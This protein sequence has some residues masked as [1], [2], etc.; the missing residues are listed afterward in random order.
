MGECGKTLIMDYTK[1]IEKSHEQVQL[2]S[3]NRNTEKGSFTKQKLSFAD[4]R[5]SAITQRR[6]QKVLN[7]SFQKGQ[8]LPIQRE[9]AGSLKTINDVYLN[10]FIG[11][12][13]Q[14][15][16]YKT[17]QNV[18][19]KLQD[20]EEIID[21]DDTL[22]D[23]LKKLLIE[24]DLKT[25]ALASAKLES[26]PVKRAP[27]VARSEPE[28]TRGEPKVARK[29]PISVKSEQERIRE[30]RGAAEHVPGAHKL[31]PEPAKRAPEVARSEPEPTAVRDEP[32]AAR[33]EPV[34]VKS[35]QEVVREE[36]GAA[37]HVPGPHNI[38]SLDPGVHRL[39]PQTLYI[40]NLF[41]G[42]NRSRDKLV[43]GFKPGKHA[44][45]YLD[46]LKDYLKTRTPIEA[47]TDARVMISHRPGQTINPTDKIPID[48]VMSLE[49]IKTDSSKPLILLNYV[50]TGPDTGAGSTTY[51][52][53]VEEI[54]T[55]TSASPTIGFYESPSGVKI[56]AVTQS[57]A[58]NTD[59]IKFTEYDFLTPIPADKIY[60]A[61]NDEG[62]T[63]A[64]NGNS[65][66]RVT[67][68]E[69]R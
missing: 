8:V 34:P 39:I 67:D 18:L 43:D 44:I 37:E 36:R 16:S 47:E 62:K 42:D 14:L 49:K 15:R 60:Y 17:R 68:G 3:L 46:H 51:L 25:P 30:E 33:K 6:L 41:R 11:K 66:F 57:A 9:L 21:S 53:K 69:A 20:M 50:C 56:L 61:S 40:K 58:S 10:S 65:W 27:E 38:R 28:P 1:I 12:F 19:K 26:E 13:H 22:V 48:L 35:E 7:N 23:M 59:T 4:N 52:I 45:G 54:F 24:P 32:K 64:D 55:C 29:E 2:R 31:E 63:Q 5:P